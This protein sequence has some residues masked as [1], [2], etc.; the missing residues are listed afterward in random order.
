MSPRKPIDLAPCPFCGSEE[1]ACTAISPVGA[2]IAIHCRE[3][4]AT[5][6]ILNLPIAVADL[7]SALAKSWNR[8]PHESLR[9]RM[10]AAGIQRT[11]DEIG[12]GFTAPE[13]IEEIQRLL[14]EGT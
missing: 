2:Q 12:A 11:I 13:A 8:R 3:C 10:L 14:R 7:A 6:P 9:E 5:G 4:K 1:M